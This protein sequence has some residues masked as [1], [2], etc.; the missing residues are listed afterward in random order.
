MGSSTVEDV[1]QRTNGWGKIP[2]S[3]ARG[4]LDASVH[5]FVRPSSLHSS[6]ERRTKPCTHTCSICEIMMMK[7]MLF[8]GDEGVKDFV[9]EN[10]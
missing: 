9:V 10:K 3:S 8:F 2:E 7:P 5:G 1:R 4:L 6:H